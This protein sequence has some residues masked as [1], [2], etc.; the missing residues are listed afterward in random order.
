[1]IDR[2]TPEGYRILLEAR[3]QLLKDSMIEDQLDAHVVGPVSIFIDMF[4][5][6]VLIIQVST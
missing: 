3:D 5:S 6:C 4:V 1:L 2:G